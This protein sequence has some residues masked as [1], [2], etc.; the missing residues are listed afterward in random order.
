MTESSL[1]LSDRPQMLIAFETI[2]SGIQASIAQGS[3][4]E[5]LKWYAAVTAGA[6]RIVR[7]REE[8]DASR[9]PTPAV[10]VL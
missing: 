10:A 7:D 4:T 1:A 8:R 3:L 6:T 2:I 9:A 5:E